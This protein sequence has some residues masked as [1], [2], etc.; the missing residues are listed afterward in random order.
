[1]A[2]KGDVLANP[3]HLVLLGLAGLFVATSLAYLVSGSI[4]DS[5]PAGASDASRRAALW[6]DRHGPRL[7]AAELALMLPAAALLVAF[8]RRMGRA[9]RRKPRR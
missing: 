7:L 1:M 8:D 5:P 2:R 6:F 9:R 3:F 4:L